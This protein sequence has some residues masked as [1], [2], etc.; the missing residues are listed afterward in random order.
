MLSAEARV[1]MLVGLVTPIDV[2]PGA[3]GVK[4]VDAVSLP[5]DMFT[6]VAM[7]PTV[8]LLFCKLI[9]SDKPPASACMSPNLNVPG[10]SQAVWT[11]TFNGLPM[12][13]GNG[14]FT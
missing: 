13:V 11:E 9:F 10:S 4:V 5:P 7:L 3:N 1:T 12:L 8:G 14:K 6:V 2:V